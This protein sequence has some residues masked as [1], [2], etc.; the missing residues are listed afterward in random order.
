MFK[1]SATCPKNEE[2]KGKPCEGYRKDGVMRNV[3]AY[4]SR[5]RKHVEL[6]FPEVVRTE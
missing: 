6:K 3:C 2:R 5:Y 1:D 4:C